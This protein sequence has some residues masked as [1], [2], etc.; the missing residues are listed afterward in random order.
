MQEAIPKTRLKLDGCVAD[1][2]KML[3][4]YR[5]CCVQTILN[6]LVDYGRDAQFIS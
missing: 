3:T 2:L 6:L 5:V 1:Q 4:Y